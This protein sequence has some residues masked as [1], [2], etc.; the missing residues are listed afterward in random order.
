MEYIRELPK[1]QTFCLIYPGGWGGENVIDL[2]TKHSNDYIHVSACHEKGRT[3]IYSMFADVFDNSTRDNT[4]D[5]IIYP[6]KEPEA[7]AEIMEE[8]DKGKKYLGAGHSYSPKRFIHNNVSFIN[9]AV[10]SKEELAYA[11]KLRFAKIGLKF[12]SYNPYSVD[13]DY[14]KSEQIGPTLTYSDLE[15]EEYLRTIFQME[16]FD[17]KGF[18]KGMERW[19]RKNRLILHRLK[20]KYPWV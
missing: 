9:A 1:G 20:K 18:S 11:N 10:D 12:R 5:D 8:L 3:M 6:C 7:F 15:D 19:Y 17:Y 2:I 13:E 14:F 4:L 16:H